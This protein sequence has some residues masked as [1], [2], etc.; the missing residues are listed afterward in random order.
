MI[1][2]N[3]GYI[4]PY[5]KMGKEAA[6]PLSFSA[7]Y[8][9]HLIRGHI[10]TP[11]LPFLESFQQTW[12]EQ[13]FSSHLSTRRDTSAHPLR[14]ACHKT[15]MDHDGGKRPKA[16]AAA[17]KGKWRCLHL[18]TDQI[19]KLFYHNFPYFPCHGQTKRQ[20]NSWHCGIK[21]RCT[22]QKCNKG[23]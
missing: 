20:R 7:Q 1:Y 18:E 6:L 13:N 16:S 10:S 8:V 5:N 12:W 4:K 17:H 23:H 9:L 15:L 19:K 11:L 22:E 21:A 14:I 2:F 3:L